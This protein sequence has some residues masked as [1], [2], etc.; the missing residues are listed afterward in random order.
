MDPPGV[1]ALKTTPVGDIQPTYSQTVVEE[2]QALSLRR[3]QQNQVRVLR[4]VRK[5][6]P[7]GRGAQF[8]FSFPFT[9]LFIS[10]VLKSGSASEG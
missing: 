8:G 9:Y 10:K 7:G 3:M 5:S 4:R 1:L 6:L 2:T